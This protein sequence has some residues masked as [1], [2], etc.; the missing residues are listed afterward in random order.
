[1]VE[2]LIDLPLH[3]LWL[4]RTDGNCSV[5]SHRHASTTAV[6][7]L[8][9]LLSLSLL[10]LA[11]SLSLSLSHTHTHTNEAHLV[12]IN[13]ISR[14]RAKLVA[15]ELV[16]HFLFSQGSN[17]GFE[18]EP[19]FRVFSLCH[20]HADSLSVQAFIFGVC[21]SFCHFYGLMICAWHV[22]CAALNYLLLFTGFT[23]MNCFGF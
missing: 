12:I 23:V 17:N 9:S 4:L 8:F 19:F 22:M 20:M 14:E 3:I 18:N 16:G 10:S 2:T 21:S 7:R 13:E 11:L 1:M 5:F 6:R 15:G